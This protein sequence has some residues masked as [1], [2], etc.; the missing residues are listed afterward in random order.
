MVLNVK[1]MERVN[2]F[3]RALFSFETIAVAWNAYK[4]VFWIVKIRFVCVR[5][6]RTNTSS[7]AF[8]LTISSFVDSMCVHF[9]P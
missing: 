2:V 6:V 1:R 8:H 5:T 9:L 4:G 7:G 3:N